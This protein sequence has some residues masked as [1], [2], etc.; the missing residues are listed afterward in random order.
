MN[1]DK[2][3][4]SKEIEPIEVIEETIKRLDGKLDPINAYN[5]AQSLKYILRAGLKEGESV[6]KDLDKALNYLTRGVTGKWRKVVSIT[7]KSDFEL[8]MSKYGLNKADN[9]YYTSVCGLNVCSVATLKKSIPN[10]YRI[11]YDGEGLASSHYSIEEL[12]KALDEYFN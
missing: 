9:G 12:D 1:H 4:S 2:H 10:M 3:Y 5:V 11:Y 6:E 8:I 7:P